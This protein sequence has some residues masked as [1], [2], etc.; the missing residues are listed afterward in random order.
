MLFKES[1]VSVN[2]SGFFFFFFLKG[3][4]QHTVHTFLMLLL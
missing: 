3:H 1:A 2:E 4:A